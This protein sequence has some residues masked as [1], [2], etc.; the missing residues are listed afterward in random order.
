M[1]ETPGTPVEAPE[2]V[3][4]S[5]SAEIRVTP[6]ADQ[7]AI[8]TACSTTIMDI[9]K[10]VPEDQDCRTPMKVVTL[11]VDPMVA[12]TRRIKAI[13]E[14]GQELAPHYRV[15]IRATH[16]VDLELAPHCRVE[17]RDTLEVD[18]ELA[19]LCRVEIRDTHEVDLIREEQEEPQVAT[20][21][22]HEED[23]TRARVT[24]AIRVT[25]ART[26]VILGTCRPT[27]DR[28]IETVE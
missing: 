28:D 18:L 24:R 19:P 13:H 6:E 11:G 12:I 14:V 17:I 15:E 4:D 7:V 22:T 8:P 21:V 27:V 3:R 2:P 9:R 20:K 5:L 10:V 26:T 16:E 25:E 1:E 23:P